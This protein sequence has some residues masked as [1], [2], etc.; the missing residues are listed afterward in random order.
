MSTATHAN[1]RRTSVDV[2]VFSSNDFFWYEGRGNVDASDL[3]YRPGIRPMRFRVR[4]EKTGDLTTF[5]HQSQQTSEGDLLCTQ[6][7]ATVNG[8]VVFVNMWND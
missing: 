4:S 3:G 1:V 8:R 6:Y 7:I 2:P 5:W